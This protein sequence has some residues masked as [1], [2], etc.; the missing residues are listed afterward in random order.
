MNVSAINANQDIESIVTYTYPKE[1]KLNWQMRRGTLCISPSY[2]I[3]YTP[4]KHT[5]SENGCCSSSNAESEHLHEPLEEEPSTPPLENNPVPTQVF[6][7]A[8]PRP[9]EES[10]APSKTV[11]TTSFNYADII[12]QF[13][14]VESSSEGKEP[15]S[16]GVTVKVF[17]FF[18]PD[19]IKSPSVSPS[20]ES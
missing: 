9:K 1:K 5:Y 10:S 16:G 6:V 7:S 3:A 18:F 4:P 12:N 19:S 2:H 17:N 11:S 13:A 15:P 14:Q 20:V 8:E